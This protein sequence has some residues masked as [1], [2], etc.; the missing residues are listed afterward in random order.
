VHFTRLC[1]CHESEAEGRISFARLVSVAITD[2][3]QTFAQLDRGY[4][5]LSKTRHS[6]QSAHGES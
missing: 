3:S 2:T 5:F 6:P 4:A 1:R